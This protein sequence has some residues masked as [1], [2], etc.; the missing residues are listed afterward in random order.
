MEQFCI[1]DPEKSWEE[2]DRMIG[3]AEEFCQKL[4]LPYRIVNI[5]SGSCS[6]IV[7]SLQS[8]IME[9]FYKLAYRYASINNKHTFHSFVCS[10]KSY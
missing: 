10:A 9:M 7:Y 5:V 8:I 3:N 1:V 2:F 6:F 4:K